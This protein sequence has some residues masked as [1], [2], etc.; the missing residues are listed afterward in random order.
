MRSRSLLLGLL[1]ILMLAAAGSF[2]ET[3]CLYPV[4]ATDLSGETD[5]AIDSRILLEFDLSALPSEAMIQHA[6]L[7]LS[8]DADLPWEAPY[9]PVTVGALTRNW[10]AS[11]ASWDGFSSDESWQNPGGDWDSQLTAY[12]VLVSKA[13]APAK[14]FLTHIVKRWIN[15]EIPNYGIIA[16]IEEV[17]DL[18]DVVRHFNAETLKPSLKIRYFLPSE[19]TP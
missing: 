19:D 13:R 2:A 9:V 12:R 11:N 8:D 18:Q 3:I 1:A 6:D 15:G 16:M 10:D 17:A 5:F 14:F 4:E 7:L